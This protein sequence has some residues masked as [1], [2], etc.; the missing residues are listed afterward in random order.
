M[1]SL[2][3]QQRASVSKRVTN[4]PR[5]GKIKPWQQYAAIIGSLVVASVLNI[6]PLSVALAWYRPMWLAVVLVF[7]LLSQPSR[8]GIG[9]A[10]GVGLAAD[11]LLDSDL[12]QQALCAVLLAFFVKFIHVYL[13]QPSVGLLWLV[14][15]VGLLIYQ[16][17]FVVLQVL[18]QGV[19]YPQL[20]I[21]PLV[22][23]LIY[24]LVL[25]AL[26]RFSY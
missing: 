22:S 24:P 13:R 11:L 26:A 4:M 15:A 6:Y 23:A 9:A 7:W 25:W 10:F 2:Q 8:V 3:R 18:T 21:A 19:F 5:S 14:A 20:L 17:A 1:L 12:G 16:L